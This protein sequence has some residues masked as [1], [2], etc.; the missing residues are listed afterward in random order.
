MDIPRKIDKLGRI[1]LPMDFRKALGLEGEAEVVI[2]LCG[3][4][5]TVRGTVGCCKICGAHGII[6]QIEVCD[7]CAEEIR[8]Y[9][10]ALI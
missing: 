1:V 7:K 6:P 10:G 9:R 5:I 8:N 2:G 4:T 3:D